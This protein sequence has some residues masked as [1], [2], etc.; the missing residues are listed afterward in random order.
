MLKSEIFISEDRQLRAAHLNLDYK[1]LSCI[2][3]D[4]GQAIRVSDP[5]LSRIDVSKPR[6]LAW[7]NLPP[8]DLPP[9]R[10]FSWRDNSTPLSFEAKI[11]QFHLEE[12]GE[13]PERPVELSNSEAD[14][15]RFSTAHSSRL[16][17][18]R[19]D[20]S[21]K[22]EEGG[23]DLKQRT[24][25]KGLLANRNKGLASKDVPKTQVP[26]SRPPPPLPMIAVGLLPNPDLKRKRK[27]QEVEEGEVIPPK[28]AKQPKNAKDKRAP[29]VE[30]RE[31][32]SGAKV[33]VHT[34]A[35]QLEMDSAPIPW[36]AII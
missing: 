7:R 10:L 36:D 32:S 17:V 9:T 13:V 25:L 12:E 20:I 34:W 19:V 23:M 35:P 18:A 1:P 26:L 6:F 33:R 3:Q 14:L 29:F 27:V 4:V 5:R 22:D 30:S 24:S 28:G 2:F 11:D 21:S 31:E 16:I 15:D 8:I